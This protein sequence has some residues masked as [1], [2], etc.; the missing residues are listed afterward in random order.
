MT[1][2]YFVTG[3]AGFLGAAIIDILIKNNLEVVCYDNSSRGS[4]AKL[5][6]NIKNIE[7]IEGDIRDEEKVVN[8]SKECDAI[9]HLAFINGTEYFYKMPHLVLD[10]GIKGI[11]NV[12][13]ASKKNKIEELIVASSS[14]VY[15]SPSIIPTPE[16]IPLIV[17]DVFNPRYSYGSAK[18][19]SEILCI[20]SE[21]IFKRMMIFRPHNVYGPDMG[22][23]HVIPQFINRMDSLIKKNKKVSNINFQI[24]GDGSQTRSFNYVDDFANGVLAIIKNGEH[25]NIYHI[26]DDR[27]FYIKEVV[28]MIAAIM[29]VSVNIISGTAP[30]GETKRRCPDITKIKKLAY[31][32]KVNLEDGLK[33]TIEWYCSNN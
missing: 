11:Q 17:P 12:L 23:E 33:S 13:S 4:K 21:N 6:N 31:S 15:Q 20:H 22:N 8:S 26:G 3:G 28:E 25:N 16:N 32:P 18:I 14:E 24:L 27:E 10:V 5:K 29:G 2:K 30:K 19:M 9:I 7:F 1:K